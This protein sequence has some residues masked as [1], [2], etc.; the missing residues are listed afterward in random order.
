MRKACVIGW[1]VRQSR[2]PLV[3]GYW[4]EKYG[5]DGAY[6][7]AEIAPGDLAAF[8]G[9]LAGRGYVG[10]N[11]TAPHKEE[12][13]RLLDV[14][15]P[16]AERLRA[17]NTL[18]LEGGKLHGANTDEVGFLGNLDAE[19]PGWDRQ[20]GE[21]VVLGAGGASRSVVYGLLERGA[22]IVHV[23]NRSLDRAGE[24]VDLFGPRLRPHAFDALPDLLARADLLVNAT[25]LGMA[26]KP[27]LE[28]DLAPLNSRAI[29]TDLVYA[30]LE[31]VLLAAARSRGHRVVD[32]LGMLLHQAV[33]GFE[34]WFGRRPEV[35]P[36]LRLRIVA[37]LTGS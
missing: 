9:D 1:P 24:L 27:P 32:G 31:T 16:S 34:R 21:A 19:A 17:A 25:S 10:G 35:T 18:W 26:G 28:I 14:A 12:A 8:L 36:E 33:P 11:V 5:V 23:V 29:V 4:L 13:F 2:S 37:D 15:H 20:L 22:G 7:R 6:E 30:P 3:H